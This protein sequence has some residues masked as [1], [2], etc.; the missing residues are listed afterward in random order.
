M[1]PFLYNTLI[2]AVSVFYVYAVVAVMDFLVKRNFIPQDISRKI[3]HIA[4]GS[5]LIFW[6]FF[7]DTHW[8][9]YFNIAPALI[10]AILL[11]IKGFTADENDEAV[12]TMTRTGDRRELLKGPLY[13]TIIMCIMGTV[14]YKTFFAFTAMGI[15][16]WGDGLAPVFGKRFGKHKFKILS[17]KSIEGSV[18][19]LIFGFIGALVFN[20]I[21]GVQIDYKL[22]LLITLFAT[23]IEAI[24]PKDLDNLLIPVGVGIAVILYI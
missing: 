18:A 1:S 4:A 11:L 15:L 22:L 20:L 6:L 24:S 5:W 16:G 17:D 7:D 14:Y 12:K 10:W 23:L 8:S 19:F 9:K 2:S 21:F 13:F 3:V